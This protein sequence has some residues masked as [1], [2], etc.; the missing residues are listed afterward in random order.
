MAITELKY[1]LGLD[2]GIASVGWAVVEIDPQENPISLIDLGVRTFE[3]AEVP[4]TGESLNLSRR[5]A[6]SQRRLI[7]RRAHR[8]LR[9]KR[10]LKR[11]G[12]L[13]AV[14]CGKDFANLRLPNNVWSLRVAGLDRC[15]DNKEWA[16]VLLHLVKHRGYLSQRKNENKT[17][18]KELGALLSGVNAN[19]QLLLAKTYRSPAEIAEQKFASEKG[20]IR[21]KAGD[22]AHTFNR[23]DLQAEM[24]LLFEKQAKLGNPYTSASFQA[25]CIDLL[26]T[27]RAPLS[28]EAILNMLGHCTFEPT[29]YKAAKNTYS[30]ERF[31]WL[32]KLNN[33]RILE[34]GSE[35]PLLDAERQQLLN[36]PYLKAKLTYTQVRKIL[37]LSEQARF[38][39]RYQRDK[40]LEESEK[41]TLMEMKSYHA[42]RKALEGAGLKT[43]WQGLATK[44][45]LLDRIGTAF[46]LYK[47]DNDIST[48]LSDK[49]SQPILNALL[50]NINF[51]KFIN[52]SLQSLRRILSLMEQ[53]ERYDTA[54]KTIY[55]DHYGAK[56]A[57]LQLT[58][59]A[60]PAD[61]IRNP[62]VLRT[63]SQTRK[64]INAVVRRY[65]SPAYIHIETGREV[66]KSFKD[67]REIEKRQE[68]NQA[69]RQRAVEKFKELFPHF[70]SEPKGKDILKMRLYE[71][72][73]GKCLYSGKAIDITR[74]N[75]KGYV[76]VDHA[77]PFSRTWDDSFNNKVLVLA[78]ENQ[79]KGNQTPYE[80]LDGKHN[81][82]RWQT[83]NALVRGCHFPYAKKQRILTAALDEESFKARN[84]ND[85]RY[86]AR[87]LSQFITENMQLTG[88][89]KRQVFTSNG[90]ITAL[91]RARWGLSKVREENDRHHALDAIVV[92]CTTRAMQ[93]R[94]TDFV[95]QK[96]MNA[97]SGEY[98]D[99]ATGE[100]KA[101]HFP[102][103]WTFFHREVMIRVFDDHPAEEVIIQLPSRPQAN[104]SFV[105]PLF[106]SRMPTRK[107]T[108]QGHLETIKS[109]KRLTENL[110]IQKVR[111]NSLKLSDLENM[112]NRERE[113]ELY[114]A[115]KARLEAFN[116]DP[117]KAFAEPFYK[118][119]GQ[120]V[121]AIRVE[122]TQKSGVIVRNGNG[123]ADNASMVRVDVFIKNGKYFLVPI[124]TWQ[125]AQGILPNKAVIAYEEEANWEEMDENAHFQ[126]SLYA[127]DLIKLTTKKGV[128]FGYYSAFNRATG[129]IDIKVHD[130]DKK[131]EK[132]KNGVYQ[133]LGVKLAISFEKFQVDELG[134]V[135][136]ACKPS[137]RQPVR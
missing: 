10:L 118:K 126:F 11:E 41:A 68:Q 3:K 73:Q 120:Q 117:Q 15:L 108:G 94:I 55:G 122:R 112:V 74:L 90:Q 20:H 72:Q 87:F 1:I 84:L 49:I 106:V 56:S 14:D 103:P 75:E 32:T 124:Y 88:E 60:I 48:Y 33:L 2:L 26:M 83:F 18:D 71:Q 99:R 25:Q 37:D 130:L 45:D 34:S 81:S 98:V 67:R 46:S 69:E 131:A 102:E 17:D 57:E 63:L 35:R 77:L 111:L 36:Q 96:E 78:I 119:G 30:A 21:N 101:L 129:A 16:A 115:L 82:L 53:G 93:K 5:L 12:V 91:L 62:V 109:A 19:H 38:N 40:T 31:I 9:M 58:L 13:Q 104:H 127:N 114:Q 89:K 47:T 116:N 137:K 39:I 80:W 50:E 133:G 128:F 79:N 44:P 95:R 28:G 110:S 43:E 85:T 113:T 6:R 52:L 134:K 97:F 24:R 132:T 22:Y 107:M 86:V 8:L 27:Q 66:G 59:P 100:I 51:D 105:T 7:R 61:E 54:C 4:K 76:E 65:G 121:K 23:L 92:A 123:I 135:I 136:R 125:V 64:I 29:E 70:V 42:I